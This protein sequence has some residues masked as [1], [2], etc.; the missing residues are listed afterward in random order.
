MTD[1]YCFH[2]VTVTRAFTFTAMLTTGMTF[3]AVS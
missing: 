3:T 1:A 2:A